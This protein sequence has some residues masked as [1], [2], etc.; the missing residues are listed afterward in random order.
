MCEVRPLDEVAEVLRELGPVRDQR[1]LVERTLPGEPDE[2]CNGSRD[3]L[4]RTGAGV[5]LLDVD[6]GG[7]VVGHRAS[8]ENDG[9]G[10]RSRPGQGETRAGRE[11]DRERS[12]ARMGTMRR[13]SACGSSLDRLLFLGLLTVD[14]ARLELLLLGL[15]RHR[16]ARLRG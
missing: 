6:A 12:R 9:C 16:R 7:V 14:A 15:A 1:R 2:G 10:T 5:D 11:I 3:S 13:P 4:D 8:L